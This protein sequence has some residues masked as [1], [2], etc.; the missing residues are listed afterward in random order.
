MLTQ[1]TFLDNR[2]EMGHPSFRH[3]ECGHVFSDDELLD[4]VADTLADPVRDSDEEEFDEADYTPHYDSDSLPSVK[5]NEHTNR[6][7]SYDSRKPDI[8]DEGF[9]DACTDIEVYDYYYGWKNRRHWKPSFDH[10]YVFPETMPGAFGGTLPLACDYTTAE[11][12]N[13]RIT[14]MIFEEL[15]HG[16]KCFMSEEAFRKWMDSLG[17]DDSPKSPHEFHY[18]EPNR[19]TFEAAR[20][21]LLK[22]ASDDHD[23]MTVLNKYVSDELSSQM[24]GINSPRAIKKRP[25]R[26]WRLIALAASTNGWFRDPYGKAIVHYDAERKVFD[27]TIPLNDTVVRSENITEVLDIYTCS[28]L[29]WNRID[30][31]RYL[32]IPKAIDCVPKMERPLELK[33]LETEGCCRM[34]DAWNTTT[35]MKAE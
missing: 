6:C 12:E 32:R 13:Q 26:C 15:P 28:P 31:H 24:P 19:M 1:L 34:N 22:T 8:S 29:K 18:E 11:R 21:F 30:M 10:P 4:I 23:L 25:V 9:D 16:K 14:K 5:L 35:P 20:E 2:R 17:K 3:F 7:S 33:F 27:A